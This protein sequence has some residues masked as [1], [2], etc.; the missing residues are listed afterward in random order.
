MRSSRM[1]WASVLSFSHVGSC[2]L[3]RDSNDISDQSD[4]FWLLFSLI[5]F[6]SY[7][8]KWSQQLR[9]LHALSVAALWSVEWAN[10]STVVTPTIWL[11]TSSGASAKSLR[12]NELWIFDYG[13][14]TNCFLCIRRNRFLPL[15]WLIHLQRY[16]Y[17][18]LPSL[19]FE[20]VTGSNDD[21]KFER[22]SRLRFLN[23]C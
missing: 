1:G 10:S 21:P 19:S 11:L 4:L 16:W 17:S 6:R 9:L 18:V 8:W 12:R 22:H 3:S 7:H 2:L 5:P 14:Q 23:D 20:H 13:F 15:L